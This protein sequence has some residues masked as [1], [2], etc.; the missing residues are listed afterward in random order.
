MLAEEEAQF[1]EKAE[2]GE[3]VAVAK[4]A[5][6][7]SEGTCPPSSRQHGECS[8]HGWRCILTRVCSSGIRMSSPRYVP[9][10]Q[11]SRRE[12]LGGLLP[13]HLSPAVP[14]W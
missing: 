2:E 1:Q 9:L 11:I 13:V 14:P 7:I 10:D 8:I 12:D 3:V 4:S 5:V 6:M